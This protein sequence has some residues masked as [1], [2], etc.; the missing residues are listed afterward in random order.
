[1]HAVDAPRAEPG[2]GVPPEFRPQLFR[3]FTR[4]RSAVVTGTGLGLYVV[5]TLAEAQGGSV[6]YA[7]GRPGAVSTLSLVPA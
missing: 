1:M 4:G 2:D 3:E 6:S 5:R 7:P